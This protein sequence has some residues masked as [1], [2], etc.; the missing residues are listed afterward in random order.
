MSTGGSVRDKGIGWRRKF[1]FY[2]IADLMQYKDL[3]TDSLVPQDGLSEQVPT[4][5]GTTDIFAPLVVT[6]GVL[7]TGASFIIGPKVIPSDVDPTKNIGVG[8]VWTHDATGGATAI[9]WVVTYNVAN[10]GVGVAGAGLYAS[11]GG[12]GAT[13]AFAE[14]ITALDTGIVGQTTTTQ[15]S[16]TVANTGE[17]CITPRG[18][19][20]ANTLTNV[21]FL[22]TFRVRLSVFTGGSTKILPIGL[23]LD[24]DMKKTY[25]SGKL[26]TT[27]VPVNYLDFGQAPSEVPPAVQP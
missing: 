1:L 14:P 5:I 6:A 19:I 17:I 20:K 3:S 25:G 18:M 7:D 16:F 11:S 9:T 23:L 24:Y 21:A 27:N 15:G 26:T 22:W 2:P 8:V 12:S 10:H 13:F 4:E